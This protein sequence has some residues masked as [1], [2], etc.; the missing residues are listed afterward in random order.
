MSL[1]TNEMNEL[2]WAKR[3]LEQSHLAHRLARGIANRTRFISRHIP[4]EWKQTAA[5]RS[6]EAL[7]HGLTWVSGTLKAGSNVRQSRCHLAGACAAG[8]AGGLLGAPA[9]LVE[10]PATTL[11]M[12][13]SVANIASVH[14][15]DMRS[16]ESRLQCLQVFALGGGEDQHG[17]SDTS[18]YAIRANMAPLAKAAAQRLADRL[19]NVGGDSVVA[20]FIERI[21]ARFQ[22][23][24]SERAG[25]AVAP[26]IGAVTGAGVNGLFTHQMQTLGEA[27]FTVRRLERRH[28]ADVVQ[29]AYEQIDV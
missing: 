24:V 11:I 4:Q 3:R 28:G 9:L 26:V 5:L 25:A 7:L 10:L 12:L 27:H 19:G 21:A 6:H 15:E 18:Y 22:I 2:I 13:R 23:Q 1:T 14:G 17:Q 20:C 16:M 29:A 8:F